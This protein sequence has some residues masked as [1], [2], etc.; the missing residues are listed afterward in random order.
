MWKWQGFCLLVTLANWSQALKCESNFFFF[1][2]F[3]L[4]FVKLFFGHLVIGQLHKLFIELRRSQQLVF[5]VF[6]KHY[7]VDSLFFDILSIRC[8]GILEK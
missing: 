6:G 4:V 3:G 1:F 8:S 5:N 7:V 2:N